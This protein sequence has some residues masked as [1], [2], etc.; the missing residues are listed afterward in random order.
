MAINNNNKTVKFEQN[1][2]IYEA[3]PVQF[4]FRIPVRK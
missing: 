1:F 3:V 2:K 4:N